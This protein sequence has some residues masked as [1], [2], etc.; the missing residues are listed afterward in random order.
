METPLASPPLVY[1]D[2]SALGRLSDP[3]SATSEAPDN[4]RRIL[5]EAADVRRIVLA[6]EAGRLALLGSDALLAEV[7]LAPPRVQRVSLDVLRL[8]R[9]HVPLAPTRAV[10]DRLRAQLGFRELDALHIA[11]AYT[12]GARYAV[13]CDVPHWLRRAARVARLLGP[14]PAIVSP[15]ECARQE[16]L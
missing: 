14:G 13:S 6:C 15:A 2:T 10:A 11:A 5:A 16:G 1:L 7:L 4:R 12:G 3:P 8:A 9:R